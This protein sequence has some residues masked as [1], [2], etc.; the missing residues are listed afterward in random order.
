MSENLSTNKPW[1]AVFTALLLLGAGLIGQALWQWQLSGGGDYF[2]TKPI[3]NQS[4]REA[5]LQDQTLNLASSL[6]AERDLKVSVVIDEAA[7]Q[8]RHVLLLINR[9]EVDAALSQALHEMVWTGLALRESRGDRVTLQFRSFSRAPIG[10][11]MLVK[12]SMFWRAAMGLG[13]VVLAT[14]GLLIARAGRR[15]RR[16]K[17]QQFEDYREQL[18]A[19]KTIA[20][21]E[22]VRIAGVLSDWLNG[23]TQ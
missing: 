7:A 10:M 18:R 5:Y 16:A 8:A 9:G 20:N 1:F 17:A 11:A 3:D 14:I 12:Q 2:R 6:L 19:L 15:R 23:E 22:P 21:E 13:L 4:Q